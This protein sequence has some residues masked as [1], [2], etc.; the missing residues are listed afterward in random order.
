[1]RGRRSRTIDQGQPGLAEERKALVV[2]YMLDAE[3]AR[4]HEQR[5]AEVAAYESEE[6]GAARQSG[7]EQSGVRPLP[8]ARRAAEV[9][10]YE[11]EEDGAVRQ[12]G[13]Q[14]SVL[15]PLS[16]TRP[17]GYV[18]KLRG[19]GFLWRWAVFEGIGVPSNGRPPVP[20]DPA[21]AVAAGV[22]PRLSERSARRAA[23]RAARGAFRHAIASE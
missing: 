6:N 14:Q 11:S 22:L 16:A 8:P 9:A 12:S 7:E 23:E 15:R 17:A 2:R 20:S 1:M 21:R 19:I 10:A 5:A 3:E 13:K 4:E 18:I